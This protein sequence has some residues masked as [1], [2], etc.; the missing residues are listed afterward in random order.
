ML[1]QTGNDMHNTIWEADINGTTFSK[2]CAS[3]CSDRRRLFIEA[4]YADKQFI[5]TSLRAMY[6]SGGAC[7]SGGGYS[8]RSYEDML[9]SACRSNDI[10]T[11]AL[12][13][14][15]GADVNYSAAEAGAAEDA[16]ALTCLEIAAKRDHRS[17]CVM[18]L[19]NGC[20]LVDRG[21]TLLANLSEGK[22]HELVEYIAAR[23]RLG[24]G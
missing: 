21:A 7:G 4:K 23:V 20:T 1:L 12:A 5:G 9:V 10:H 14:A 18:L 19:L 6:S 16:A 24:Q 17:I 3:D 8:Y 2:P 22:R 11:A 15:H 13:I